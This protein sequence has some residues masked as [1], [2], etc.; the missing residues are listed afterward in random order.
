M[1]WNKI[2]S[3]HIWLM[4]SEGITTNMTRYYCAMHICTVHSTCCGEVSV[5][6]MRVLCRNIRLVS[7][8]TYVSY[9]TIT[10]PTAPYVQQIS[11]F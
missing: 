10:H 1:Y 2:L 3:Q 8:T 7:L 11:S 5:R 4:A 6:H 9:S